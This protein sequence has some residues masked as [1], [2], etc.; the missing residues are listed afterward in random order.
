MTSTIAFNQLNLKWS[1]IRTYFFVFI[2]AVGNLVLPQICHLIPSGGLILLP[3]YFFTLIAAYKFGLKVGLVTALCSPLLNSVLTG[4]PAM[5]VLPVILLKSVI[6]AATAAYIAGRFQKVSILHLLI[7]VL[8][9]QLIGSMAEW[10]ITQSFA[11]ATQDLTMGIP[12]MLVQV[13]G[14]YFLLKKIADLKL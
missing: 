8:T 4:M 1:D 6:L 14:G 13:L 7:V 3:V 12:G 11:K 10:G 5:E 2:F 9:Y